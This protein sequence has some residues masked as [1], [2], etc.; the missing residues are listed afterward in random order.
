M[1][2]KKRVV[3]WSQD[4]IGGKMTVSELAAWFCDDTEQLHFRII[5]D[6]SRLGNKQVRLKCKKGSEAGRVSFQ[7]DLTPCAYFTVPFTLQ[8]VGW[9]LTE[10]DAREEIRKGGLRE[11]MAKPIKVT[12]RRCAVLYYS[13]SLCLVSLIYRTV[14]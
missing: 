14:L 8:W 11:K 2:L 4:V 12:A 1:T 6:S 3:Q 7:S 9:F 5:R 10:Q 13:Q